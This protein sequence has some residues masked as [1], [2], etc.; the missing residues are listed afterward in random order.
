M[1]EGFSTLGCPELNLRQAKELADRFGLRYI[2]VR[3]ISN[4][5][6]VVGMLK[7]PDNEAIAAELAQQG[8]LT[9]L[10]SGFCLS[11]EENSEDP[12]ALVET[13]DRF[14]IPFLRVF[15][16]Y[17][18]ELPIDGKTIAITRAN[19]KR[20]DQAGGK[21]RVALETHDRYSTAARC[22]ELFRKLHRT[23]PIVWD[24]HNSCYAGETLEES[25]KLLKEYIVEIH[26][27]DSVAEP[28]GRRRAVP[29]GEG[30]FPLARLEQLI[31]GSAAPFTLEYE[32]MWERELPPLAAALEK[33]LK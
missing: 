30:D 8:R 33:L 13:A 2:V 12:A 22:L 5:C 32:R 20:F 9:L 15:G 19:L 21:V 26:A 6:D 10:C 29:P 24:A 23:L 11:Q 3:A 28:D 25:Y 4:S 17:P 31:A 14:G 16:G 7:D 27:K 18:A 1:F